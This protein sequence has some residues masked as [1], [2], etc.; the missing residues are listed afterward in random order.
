MNDE[1]HK[2][3]VLHPKKFD[4]SP[5]IFHF[6]KAFLEVVYIQRERERERKERKERENNHTELYEIQYC[7]C[8]TV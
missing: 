5:T 7:K 6:F 4:D 3:T 8:H 2:Y 1:Q